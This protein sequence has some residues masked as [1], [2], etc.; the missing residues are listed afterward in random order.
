MYAHCG[1]R[2]AEHHVLRSVGAGKV[3]DEGVRTALAAS[4][5]LMLAAYGLG[6]HDPA[7]DWWWNRVP[8]ATV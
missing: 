8:G 5:R 7:F 4:G 3:D 1:Q 2:I 6:A